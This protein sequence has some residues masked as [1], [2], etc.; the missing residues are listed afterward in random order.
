MDAL[1]GMDGQSGPSG[2]RVLQLGRI[3]ASSNAVAL[4]SVMA[5]M[6]GARPDAVPTNRIAA[7]RGLGPARAEEIQIV[8]DFEMIPRFRLPS[9]WLAGTITGI[10]GLTFYRLIQRRPT[11]DK[12]L[13][14]RCRRCADN[15]PVQAI[16][17]TP[18][19]AIDQGKCVT[20]FC[21]VEA[22]PDRAMLVPSVSR[23][24]LRRLARR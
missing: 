12:R 3:L 5:M 21:C 6:A 15:C 18:E 1:R 16:S 14:N 4:D 22:C 9:S 24:L 11:Y 2:G 13:W 8:G 20:C 10:A 23:D 17:M 19:P 7:A